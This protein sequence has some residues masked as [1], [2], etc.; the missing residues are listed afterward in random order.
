MWRNIGFK[1]NLLFYIH[2]LSIIAYADLHEFNRYVDLEIKFEKSVNT[3]NF[4]L[5][6]SSL[7]PPFGFSA[8]ILINNITTANIR[9]SNGAC[10]ISRRI[11]LKDEC[12]CTSQI[13]VYS[14]LTTVDM[15]S[16]W[17]TCQFRFEQK[18]EKSHLLIY[19]TK[20]Y[21]GSGMLIMNHTKIKIWRV[22]LHDLVSNRCNDDNHFDEAIIY[23]DFL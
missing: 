19:K 20:I 10:Y 7:V 2:L 9:S 22:L 18:N 8:E 4:T 3:V 17:F 16:L 6:C 12:S 5:T 13:Y 1:P 21:N 14:F 23:A 11:C 15:E